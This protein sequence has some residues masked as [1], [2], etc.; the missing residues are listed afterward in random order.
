MLLAA[1]M[2]VNAGVSAQDTENLT[3]DGIKYTG[4]RTT[5]TATVAGTEGD[6]GKIDVEI[7]ENVNGYTVT[8]VGEY[9]F[10]FCSIKSIQLPNTITSIGN[11]SFWF[12]G[13]L[14]NV[15]FPNHLEYIGEQAFNYCEKLKNVIIPGSVK[16]ISR[17]AFN[18]CKSIESFVVP[19]GITVIRDG[20]FTECTS[21]ESVTLPSTLISIE[22]EAFE[23]CTNLTSIEFPFS[24]KSIGVLAFYGSGLTS[25]QIPA[26]LTQIEFDGEHWPF[27]NCNLSSI[28]VLEGNPVYDSREN[29]NA[30]IETATN[31]LILGS[32]ST[33]FPTDVTTIGKFA[34]YSSPLQ[35]VE[36]PNSIQTIEEGAFAECREL[37]QVK[38]PDALTSIEFLTFCGCEKLQSITFPSTL[39]NIGERAF[40]RCEQVIS[41]ELPVCLK[42]IG[43]CA[44]CLC[45]NLQQ[46]QSHIEEPFEIDDDAFNYNA[47]LYV[48]KG[49]KD[50]YK[51]TAGWKKFKNI[52]EEDEDVIAKVKQKEETY[53]TYDLSG[54]RLSKMQRGINITNGKKVLIK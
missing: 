2:L 15:V 26:S 54:R 18:R 40:E 29:C 37:T 39:Q 23:F 49:T 16:E 17:M 1:V 27:T 45:M 48:P 14:E 51:A 13:K 46:V 33:I 44:F 22:Q 53:T 36:I 30:I 19:E 43:Y 6:F 25:L 5:M 24:L 47:T 42:S 12:C 52:V 3:I 34:F 20:T 35:C 9:A 32:T 41:L 31:T 21:L 11:C 10:M 4:D 50:K 7:P 8:G 38:L 28:A